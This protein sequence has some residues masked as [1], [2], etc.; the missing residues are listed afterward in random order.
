VIDTMVHIKPDDLEETLKIAREVLAFDNKDIRSQFYRDIILSALKSKP[1]AK[2]IKRSNGYRVKR[3]ELK[4]KMK[5]TNYHQLV[6]KVYQLFSI[7]SDPRKKAANGGWSIKEVL[8]H[9]LDSASNNHQRLL[10][11]KKKDN[12]EFPGYDQEAFVT[13]ANY[14]DFEFS[15]LLSLWYN[16]NKLLLHIYQNIRSDAVDSTFSVGGRPPV[17]LEQLFIN[18]FD[19]ME[20]HE[21][22]VE[23][24]LGS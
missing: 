1:D 11:Y 18:Y 6:E 20:N 23:D 14:K 2:V 10:R 7:C 15:T 22:Q 3:R 24:I 12:L 9:L 13:R 16:H 4:K 8:G 17:T 21:K 19:H 5:N